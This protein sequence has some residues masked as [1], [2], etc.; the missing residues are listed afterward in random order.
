MGNINSG[1]DFD[2]SGTATCC[3]VQDCRA[4]NNVVYGFSHAPGSLETTFIGNEAECN[5][6]S[7]YNII[8]GAIGLQGLSWISGNLIVLSGNA[9][10]GARFTNITA[11]FF[12]G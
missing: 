1:I 6:S 5:G 2:A 8:G 12:G 3:L 10:L 7:D 9:A 11:G 4:L